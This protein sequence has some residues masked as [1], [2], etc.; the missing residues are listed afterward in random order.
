[1]DPTTDISH[2]VFIANKTKLVSEISDGE[3]IIVDLE[4][5]AYFSL[6]NSACFFWENLL[7]GVTLTRLADLTYLRY[8]EVPL[9]IVEDLRAFLLELQAE[10]LLVRTA[11]AAMP[12]AEVS[13]NVKKTMYTRP[14]VEKFT[15]MAE[16]LLLDPI[17]EVEDDLGWPFKKNNS[18]A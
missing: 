12:S 14:I 7:A 4:T 17:H 15:D 1:M 18:A 6:Q 9:T 11:D 13:P 10:E 16:L 8:S 3:A 5:G 2:T